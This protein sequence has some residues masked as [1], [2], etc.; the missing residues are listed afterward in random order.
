MTYLYI[1]IFSIIGTAL[2]MGALYGLACTF[3]NRCKAAFDS[4]DE[5]RIAS[6]CE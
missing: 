1:A 5:A 2:I 6:W 4:G 3:D